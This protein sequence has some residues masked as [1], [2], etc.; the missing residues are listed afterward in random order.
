MY[1]LVGADALNQGK[2]C[3]V[4]AALARQVYGMLNTRQRRMANLPCHGP[5]IA[6][7]V[8]FRLIVVRHTINNVSSLTRLFLLAEAESCYA[9]RSSHLFHQLFGP[10]S[11]FT[12]SCRT[13]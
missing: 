3:D 5:E 12:R 11:A 1:E 7:N 10:T 9:E 4:V 8:V 13:C 2:V 6:R